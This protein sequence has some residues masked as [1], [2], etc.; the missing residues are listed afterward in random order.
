MPALLKLAAFA[1]AALILSA[2]TARYQAPAEAEE[3]GGGLIIRESPYSAAETLDRIEIIVVEA[4]AALF[5]RIDHAAGARREGVEMADAQLLIF[6]NPAL[7]TPLIEEARLAGLDLPLR[8]LAWEEDG[9]VRIAWT[10]PAE[11]ARRAGADPDSQA[12][13]AITGALERIT[14]RALSDEAL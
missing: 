10:D 6:G 11:I 12:V 2:C 7:G 4:G 9:S 3:A 14:A 5:A 1:A 8:V 13:A